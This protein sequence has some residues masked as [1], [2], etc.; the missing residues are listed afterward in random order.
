MTARPSE[1]TALAGAL[2]IAG[3]VRVP[4]KDL[5]QLWNSAAPRLNGDPQQAAAL[6]AAL[7]DIKDRG[8]IELPVTAWDRTTS[9]P[10][11]CSV[12]V[13]LARRA[14]RPCPWTQFPWC[15][16]LGWVAS[17]PTLTDARFDDLVAVNTWLIQTRGDQTPIVPMRY[18]SAQ[19]FGDEK[20]LENISRTNLFGVGR[21]SLEL[22][23]C[24]RI[25]PPLAA[26]RVGDGP[27]ILVVENSDPYWVA[28]KTLHSCPP[29][30]VGVVAWGAGKS[31]PSQVPTLTVDV[32][33]YG[34]AEGTVWYWGDMDPDGL[35]IATEAARLSKSGGGPPI[36]PATRLW[37]AMAESPVQ[38]A[39]T[40][41]WTNAPG[42]H[43]LGAELSARLD[44]VRTAS[45]RVAQEAV[46]S[47]AIVEWTSTVSTHG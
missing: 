32:A 35:A 18:R 15:P 31:F 2:S 19:L 1:I 11:P 30:S 10:L 12:T 9:P 5:W 26:A 13:P 16:Q 40:I 36:R 21:L 44:Q 46:P 38:S 42:R 29:H 47:T 24:V 39:G 25:P 17:L 7:N 23:S 45:G 4:L 8:I 34:P 3:K 22:L 33:G 20:R 27:D 41:D 6:A 28:V 37:A 43:W 14:A